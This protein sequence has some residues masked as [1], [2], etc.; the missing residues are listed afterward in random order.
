MSSGRCAVEK[1]AYNARAY[2][3]SAIVMMR[4]TVL[5]A[6]SCCPLGIQ[7]CVHLRVLR[8]TVQLSRPKIS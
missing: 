2:L 1:L 7:N 3:F 4:L 6:A 5:R 8:P